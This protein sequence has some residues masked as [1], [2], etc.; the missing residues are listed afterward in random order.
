MEEG[1]RFY[2]PVRRPYIQLQV[3]CRNMISSFLRAKR[4]MT[5]HCEGQPYANTQI[6]LDGE[7]V[8]HLP[9]A[10]AWWETGLAICLALF[11]TFRKYMEESTACRFEE[12]LTTLWPEHEISSS[13]ESDWSFT[14][15][16]VKDLPADRRRFR[17]L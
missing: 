17:P 8:M 9:M 7:G 15:V 11:A 14:K 6:L 2:Y 5:R 12:L 13:T 4:I 10:M 3:Q 1:Y 16:E